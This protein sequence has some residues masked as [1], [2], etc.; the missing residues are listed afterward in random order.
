MTATYLSSRTFRLL[1]VLREG[2]YLSTKDKRVR[3]YALRLLDIVD[4]DEGA[5]RAR[6][7]EPVPS[8]ELDFSDFAGVYRGPTTHGQCIGEGCYWTPKHKS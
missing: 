2:G 3:Y 4:A 8:C 6:C 5:E 7:F 1:R